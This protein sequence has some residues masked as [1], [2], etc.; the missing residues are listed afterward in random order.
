MDATGL[1]CA[2]PIP[3]PYAILRPWYGWSP[4]PGSTAIL[5]I[6]SGVV[7]ATSS[8]SMPPAS[9]TM[10]TGPRAAPSVTMPTYSSRSMSRGSSTSTASTGTPSGPVW[11]V[12]SLV[13]SIPPAAS[14]ASA[15]DETILIPPALPRPPA[16]TCALTTAPPPKA[17][18]NGAGLVGRCRRAASRDRHAA[19]G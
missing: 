4:S 6:L 3:S 16:W 11:K 8:M 13:P 15:G 19:I 18:G 7:S 14:A 2:A 10:T 17:L 5:M 9:L 1:T 12:T